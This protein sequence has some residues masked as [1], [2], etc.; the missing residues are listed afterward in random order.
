[1][2]KDDEIFD[3]DNLD[4][5]IKKLGDVVGKLRDADDALLK[6]SNDAI[7]LSKNLSGITLP[8][9]LERLNSEN[10][11]LTAKVKELSD[12]L[13]KLQGQY[14]RLSP[15]Q[16]EN[17]KLSAQER[18]ERSI[19]NRNA[20]EAAILNSNLAGAYAKLNV[21]HA[22]AARL[23]QDLIARGRLATQTQRQYNKELEDA[24]RDFDKLNQKIIAADNAVRKFNR[25]VGNYP[26]FGVLKDLISA[27]GIN[28]GAQLFVDL[29]K[30]IFETTKEIQSMDMA[31]KQVTGTQ[32]AF[33][34]SQMFLSR[35]SE[36]YGVDLGDLTKQFT[37]FYVSA[38]DKL[39]ANQ[40]ED[41]FESITKAG[42]VMGLSTQSQ[43]RAFLALN[44]MMSK[45]TIQAEELRGQLGEALPG[46]LG[47]MAK[48]LGVT[49]KQLGQMMK[50]G[51]LLAAE[52]LPKFAKQLEI[53]YG[54]ENVN[55]V[56]T[57]AA[58][59][60]RYTNAWREFVRGLDEDGNKLSNFMKRTISVA[61]DLLIGVSRLAES[62]AQTRNR[63]LKTLQE[64]A[65]NET[66]GY[67]KSLDEIRKEDLLNDK[68]YI[69]EKSKQDTEEFNRLKSRNLILKAIAKRGLDEWGMR[70]PNMVELEKNQKR[71]QEIN[72]LLSRRRGQVQA[73]NKLLDE[74]KKITKEDTELTK[75]QLKAIEDALKAKYEAMKKE[76]ELE[77]LK[78]ETILNNENNTYKEQYLALKIY[79]EKKLELI[80]LDYNEH[81]RL[82]KGNSDKIKSADFDRQMA[83]IKNENDFAS[84]IKSIRKRQ[85]DDYIQEIKSIEDFLKKY[86]EEQF[87]R[88]EAKEDLDVKIFNA[89]MARWEKEYERLQELKK[90][91]KE[92]QESFAGEVFNN[93]GLGETFNSF[94]K[95]I[96]GADGKMTTMFQQLLDGAETSKEKFGVYFNAIAQSAQEAFNFISQLTTKNFEAEKQRLD[97]QY[98]VALKYAGDNKEAQEK[99]A[100]DL[101]AQKKDI[102]VREA[103]A[104]KKQAL[105]NIAIDTAQAIIGLWA[106]PGFPAAIP[107]AFLVGGLGLAQAAIVNAQEIPQYYMGGEHGGGKMMIND[108]QGSN[109]KETFVTPDGKIHQSDKR[110]AIV[111]APAGT[112]IYT[113]DQWLDHQKEI[114]LHNMLKANNIDLYSQRAE[115]KSMTKDDFYEVMNNTLGGQPI[116]R[117]TLDAG[118]FSEYTIRKGKSKIRMLNRANGKSNR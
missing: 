8:S 80:Q 106:S 33:A 60:N 98:N 35:I 46:A 31:L 24:Q 37:Q 6:L 3:L 69:V 55:R 19:L 1:M 93:A 85:N 11:A 4:K 15:K 25:N 36:A 65:F 79:N 113:H 47:I 89:Q 13:A 12:A 21:Q 51:Q 71:M 115:R 10:S 53:T 97:D 103:K 22:Q 86:D 73:L 29:A 107:L 82:A 63:I 18:Y 64:S 72:N 112:K 48:A 116:I 23:L 104:K 109:W 78:Q 5:G 41:I 68:S 59:Q 67:Y 16:S 90:A 28:L 92:Y 99:L 77:I 54:I 34:Q 74:G 101:E 9:D 49:E 38:K 7:T 45:G 102:A 30:D 81:V 70:D 75:A 17:A 14:S 114:S 91:T 117:P 76:I 50:D 87:A 105:V 39:S 110:N 40:I 95:Q 96:E 52:V 32:E 61:T 2:A 42:S 108:G 88:K 26:T 56:E 94:F 27:F 84:K 118:G 20:R 57:L 44:Q 66:L 62:D 111:D 83:L 43:E 58:A 100:T